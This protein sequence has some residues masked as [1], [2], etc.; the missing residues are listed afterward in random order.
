MERIK[1]SWK[2]ILGFMVVNFGGL[3]I[4][5]LATNDGVVSDWYTNLHL[6]PWTPPG[7]VFGL[8]WTIIGITFSIQ[9]GINYKR[10]DLEALV[11]FVPAFFLNILWNYTFFWLHWLWLSVIVLVG[12]SILIYSIIT[13]NRYIY[14]WKVAGWGMP[15]YLWLMV[16]TSLNLYAALAN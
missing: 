14:G 13:Y 6:A 5:G 16:A 7:W 3:Y 15:Y 8:A 4:G 1:K 9:M 10:K 11:F 12:L 2:A